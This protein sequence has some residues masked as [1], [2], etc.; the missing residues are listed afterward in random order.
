MG[1]VIDKHYEIKEKMN[2]SSLLLSRE[3]ARLAPSPPSPRP[4]PTPRERDACAFASTV[5]A[6]A[7][8]AVAAPGGLDADFGTKQPV[9]AADLAATRSLLNRSR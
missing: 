4:R 3:Q 7:P 8:A 2:F 6:V 9:L 1:V 5:A